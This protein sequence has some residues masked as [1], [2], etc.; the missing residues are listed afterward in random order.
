[1]HSTHPHSG[2]NVLPCSTLHKKLHLCLT[3]YNPFHMQHRWVQMSF[4]GIHPFWRDITVEWVFTTGPCFYLLLHFP[5]YICLIYQQTE[6]RLHMC[7]FC[8][9]HTHLCF[10]HALP[11]H[12]AP[13]PD[14][15]PGLA[16]RAWKKQPNFHVRSHKALLTWVS[17]SLNSGLTSAH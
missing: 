2:Q 1:M 7:I 13:K 4:Y 6:Q 11:L 12:L 5:F 15:N 14:F 8:L 17:Q 10:C 3:F 16:Q 9:S